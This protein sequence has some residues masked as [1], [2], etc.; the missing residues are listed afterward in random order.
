MGENLIRNAICGMWAFVI[1]IFTINSNT[2]WQGL[3]LL[4]TQFNPDFLIGVLF[5]DAVMIGLGIYFVHAIAKK[6]ES[7]KAKKIIRTK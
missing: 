3:E 6:I 7:R 4:R 2:F 5:L 1:F